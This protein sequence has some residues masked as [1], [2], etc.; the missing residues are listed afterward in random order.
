MSKKPGLTA[1]D[2]LLSVTTL[3]FDIAALELYLPLIVGAKLVLVSRNVAMEGVTLAQ[4]LA[5]HQVTVMQGTPA[6]WKLLLASGWEGKNDLTIFCGGEALDSGL[7][8]NLQQKS[9]AVCN[10]YGPT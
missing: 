1:N 5:T 7:A 3:S 2:T 10:L 8:Q 6:T 4:K 9:K